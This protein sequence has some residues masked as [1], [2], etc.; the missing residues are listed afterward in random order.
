[1]DVLRVEL[2]KGLTDVLVVKVV[3]GLIRLMIVG[4]K[5]IYASLTHR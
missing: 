4:V 3:A 5:A 1:M 2:V